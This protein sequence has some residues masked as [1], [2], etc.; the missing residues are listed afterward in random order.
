MPSLISGRMTTGHSDSDVYSEI[1]QL[2][3]AGE[4]VIAPSPSGNWNTYAATDAGIQRGDHLLYNVMSQ[5]Q[6]E[7]VEK[8]STWVRSLSFQ[9][10][11]EIHL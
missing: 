7:Y 6:C 9:K 5:D 11:S 4:A 2:A 8:I 3:R 1:D 10:P